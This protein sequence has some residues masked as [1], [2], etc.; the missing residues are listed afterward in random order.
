MVSPF[1]FNTMLQKQLSRALVAGFGAL[2]LIACREQAEETIAPVIELVSLE[3]GFKGINARCFLRTAGSSEIRECGICYGQEENALTQ[4]K[5]SDRVFPD[6]SGGTF[7]VLVDEVEEG[8][9]YFFQAYALTDDGDGLSET[10]SATSRIIPKQPIFTIPAGMDERGASGGK[11]TFTLMLT[12]T[13]LKEYGYYIKEAGP[14]EPVP[15]AAEAEAEGTKVRL[16]ASLE[17]GQTFQAEFRDLKGGTWYIVTPYG[18]NEAG[19]TVRQQPIVFHTKVQGR[20]ADHNVYEELPPVRNADGTVCLRFL[21]RNLGAPKVA[22]SPDDLENAGWMYQWG[23]PT[24]GHQV[25]TSGVTA[26]PKG[27]YANYEEVP[28][29]V[30]DK[31]FINDWRW[32]KDADSWNPVDGGPNNPCPEGYRVPSMKEWDDLRTLCGS[33]K[34]EMEQYTRYTG[35]GCDVSLNFAFRG[36]VAHQRFPKTKGDAAKPGDM[37]SGDGCGYYSSEAQADASGKWA[38]T[39]YFM[40]WRASS[41]NKLQPKNKYKGCTGMYIRCIRIP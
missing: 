40:M 23:R 20:G 17:E 24:D 8:R 36:P 26:F 41:D 25:V 4:K 29:E 15:E 35:N 5:V 39:S 37:Y 16:G 21:D 22:A 2:L 38:S 6:R 31:F 19:E 18:I 7:F 28:E 10:L 11:A 14:D 12:Y 13:K 1:K 34:D 27:G 32:S 30:R 33:K 9:E 3:P